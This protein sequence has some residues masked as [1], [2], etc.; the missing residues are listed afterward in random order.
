MVYTADFE[1][2]TDPQ[3]CRVWAYALCEI[4]DPDNV[5]FGNTLDGL[6]EFC[7]QDGHTLYFHNLKF[8][9]EFIL[10]WLFEHGY[11]FEPDRKKLTNGTFTTLI[12][13]MGAFYSME[14]VHHSGATTKIFDSLKIIP[15]S[16]DRVAKTFGL[17][18][19][20]LEIDY[21]AYREPGHV[22]TQEEQDYIRNDVTITAMALKLLFR[23][24]P[25]GHDARVQC[26]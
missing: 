22:L 16:V 19:S 17:P 20:K 23:S 6:M 2:T 26:A 10:C 11:H 13:D 24:G 18:I 14:I 15:F 5:M 3:D 9:G 8:D 21:R 25:D 12:S 7:M 1:T 4:Q